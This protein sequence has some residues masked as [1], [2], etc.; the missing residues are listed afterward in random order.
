MSGL[1]Q[2]VGQASPNN[3]CSAVFHWRGP[4]GVAFSAI[5][6]I[7]LTID[8]T[9]VYPELGPGPGLTLDEIFNV[10]TGVYQWQIL[11]EPECT[12]SG[13]PISSHTVHRGS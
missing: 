5:V 6:V 9:G 3:A 13:M 8:P 12:W 4:L 11:T 7:A 2:S 1:I 10:Q